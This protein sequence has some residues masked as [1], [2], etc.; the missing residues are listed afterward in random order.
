MKA[1]KTAIVVVIILAIGAAAYFMATGTDNEVTSGSVDR[2]AQSAAGDQEDAL[3]TVPPDNSQELT[4]QYPNLTGANIGEEI[5]ATGKQE[6][7]V[8][9]ND[10]IFEQTVLI[11]SPGTTVTW[12]NNGQMGHDISTA[13]GSEIT[14]VSSSLLTSGES[15]SHTFTETGQ[16]DYFCSPHPV[17]MRG[18][19]VVRE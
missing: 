14:G 7:Q 15:F 19:V 18:V 13:E 9:I 16:F 12:V 10:S 6:V 5:D 17:Q 1:L 4:R 8:S 2:S 3:P 11:V